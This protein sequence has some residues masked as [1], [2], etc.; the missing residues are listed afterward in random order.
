MI[1][2]ADPGH[3]EAKHSHRGHRRAARGGSEVQSAFL[4]QLQVVE[5]LRVLEVRDPVRSGKVVERLGA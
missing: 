4:D 3:V 5:E 2:A 1:R